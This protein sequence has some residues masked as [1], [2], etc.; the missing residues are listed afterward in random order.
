MFRRLCFCGLL[1]SSPIA[2]HAA[3]RDLTASASGSASMQATVSSGDP[4]QETDGDSF[5][6]NGPG[7]DDAAA[8]IAVEGRF[9][10]T[11]IASASLST[12]GNSATFN[13]S[14]TGDV[15]LDEGLNSGS[16]LAKCNGGVDIRF[17]VFGSPANYS[18]SFST[19]SASQIRVNMGIPGD[20]FFFCRDT[21]DP[22]RCDP[23][24]FPRSGTLPPGEY[25]IEASVSDS[26]LESL[27]SE[28]S[29]PESYSAG[30]SLSLTLT[31]GPASNQFTWA[32][33]PGGTY[34]EPTNW[35]PEENAP[36]THDG[37]NGDTAIFETLFE[38]DFTEITAYAVSA[39]G[40]TA[41]RFIID[42]IT[43]H[44]IGTA[45]V[46]APS[47]AQPSLTMIR[48]GRLT[49][50][51]GARLSGV[52]G[53]V[54]FTPGLPGA[55]AGLEVSGGTSDCSLSGRLIVG[56]FSDGELFLA[57]GAT[58]SCGPAILGD[59]AT[60]T[61]SIN[62]FGSRW[63]AD[64]LTVGAVSAAG[65]LQVQESGR[66]EVVG[67]I[68]V[69]E[70]STGALRL[71]DAGKVVAGEVVI[72][73]EAGA[74]G[75]LELEGDFADEPSALEANGVSS[76]L[77]VSGALRVG[78]TGD[79]LLSITNGA[80]V[81]AG[82]LHFAPIDLGSSQESRLF[83]SGTDSED[84]SSSLTVTN[85]CLLGHGRLE[86]FEGAQANF[87]DLSLGA[88]GT[89]DVNVAVAGDAENSATLITSR[90][91]VGADDFATLKVEAG[92]QVTC[93]ELAVGTGGAG[94]VVVTEGTV[95]VNGTMR[96]SGDALQGD[97]NVIIEADGAITTNALRLGDQSTSDSAEIVVRNG[98][99]GAGSVLVVLN[100]VFDSSGECSIGLDGPGVLRLENNGLALATGLARVG[101]SS[102]GGEG[103]LEIGADCKF[104]AHDLDVGGASP[105]TIRLLAASSELI[106]TGSAVVNSGGR[107]EGIGTFTGARFVNPSGFVSAGLSPGTLTINGDFEQGEG[108]TLIIEVAGLEPGKFDVLKV[109]GAVTLDGT[110]EVRFLDGFLPKE[111][112]TFEFVQADG[113]LIGQFATVTLP[114]L[115]DG[116]AAE[117]ELGDDGRVRLKAL[118]DA[119]AG[120]GTT[121]D[122]ASRADADPPP[123]A[124]C[125]A[126]VCGAGAVPML[127]LI[128]A[129][130]LAMR[131]LS[132]RRGDGRRGQ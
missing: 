84:A 94:R 118:N 24:N 106:V 6:L 19:S 86:V 111:G 66:V 107:V 108:G 28:E 8:A 10:G 109:S 126:G 78:V 7:S 2:A 130:L 110:L 51:N 65:T 125:G 61:A 55:V 41:E 33:P 25:F 47:I 32:G 77:E 101:G 46:F 3:I 83:I 102:S 85:A 35:E 54:G 56:E 82:E 75:R 93:S 127:P 115:A 31:D 68:V 38:D 60:G 17:E 131:P 95:K 16:M 119:I 112:D 80:S 81:R 52:H 117:L 114:D 99:P 123:V 58:L 74:D 15:A 124:E 30:F 72:G 48:G 39:I 73:K 18:I 76:F 44:L 4:T 43:L 91:T 49:L 92:G 129:G 21:F 62:G 103:L 128:G 89:T 34:S 64:A 23:E 97:N 87:A 45:Q 14:G 29:F 88:G 105:G 36:P 37:L 69:G 71:S 116:F 50:D 59:I 120:D 121:L 96:V 1:L 63:D 57:D 79:G 26:A 122:P 104:V 27:F 13:W 53:S 42:E 98:T 12:T 113:G 11:A 67:Q 100:G 132:R 9:T 70:R 22:S 40:A 90:L 20:S 5:Q